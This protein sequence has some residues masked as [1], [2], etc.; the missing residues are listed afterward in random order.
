MTDTATPVELSR[1]QVAALG[2]LVKMYG[3]VG[4]ARA[5]L[6]VDE[7]VW[8][9]CVA[10][11]WVKQYPTQVMLTQRGR[12]VIHEVQDQQLAVFHQVVRD[13]SAVAFAESG[14]S[15]RDIHARQYV[16]RFVDGRY[17]CFQYHQGVARLGVGYTCSAAKTNISRRRSSSVQRYGSGLDSLSD[18]EAQVAIVELF[19]TRSG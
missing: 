8:Q 6:V 5:L 19:V 9:D 12:R 7:D 18:L 2:Y 13:Y 17:F 1:S 16:G 10:H 14:P 3:V 11:G 4:I 15:L